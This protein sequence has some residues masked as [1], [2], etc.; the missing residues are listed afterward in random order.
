VYIQLAQ[1]GLET[2]SPLRIPIPPSRHEGSARVL[3]HFNDPAG[4]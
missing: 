2:Y 1:G 4:R 3:Q